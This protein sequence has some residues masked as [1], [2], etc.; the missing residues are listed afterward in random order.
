MALLMMIIPSDAFFSPLKFLETLTNQKVKRKGIKCS[1]NIMPLSA[2]V[3]GEEIQKTQMTVL[4]F[5]TRCS[6]IKMILYTRHSIR[7]CT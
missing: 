3:R 7:R 5:K 1:L 6:I 4:P 2:H